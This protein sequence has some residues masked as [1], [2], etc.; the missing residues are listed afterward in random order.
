MHA[1]AINEK[2]ESLHLKEREEGDIEGFGVRKAKGE[3]QLNSNL[4]FWKVLV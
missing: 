1:I 2:N 4:E 3:T